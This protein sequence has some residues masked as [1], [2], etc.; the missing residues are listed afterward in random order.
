MQG[1]TQDS[2]SHSRLSWQ[3]M[4]ASATSKCT[5]G[6][7]HSFFDWYCLIALLVD[8]FC[9]ARGFSILLAWSPIC[10]QDNSTATTRTVA[11]Y[12]SMKLTAIFWFFHVGEN[13][14]F[15]AQIIVAGGIRRGICPKWESCLPSGCSWNLP[16]REYHH[17]HGNETC[18]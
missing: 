11:P 16:V 5:K 2:F 6:K 13:Q 10:R 3:Q 18:H 8:S 4:R 14:M 1:R 12:I 17:L 7:M 9:S 15:S